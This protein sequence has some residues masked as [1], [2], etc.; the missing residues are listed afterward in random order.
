MTQVDL[1][2]LSLRRYVDLVKRRRWQ[3][4]PVSL[5]GLLVGG[6]V[7]FFIP[8]MYVAETVIVH[9]QLPGGTEDPE[10]PF[11]LIVETAKSSIPL[12]VEETLGELLWPEFAALDKF[13]QGQYARGVESR[14]TVLEQN[15]GDSTRSYA[16]LRVFYRD[17]D[18][19]RSAQLLNKLVQVWMARRTEE[20]RK[21]AREQ[22]LEAKEKADRALDTVLR[23]RRVKAELERQYGIDPRFSIEDQKQ[24]YSE[25]TKRHEL[26]RAA[27]RDLES[28]YD[29]L[30]AAIT[31]DEQDL[32]EMQARIVPQ[33]QLWLEAGMADKK[34]APLVQMALKSMLSYQTTFTRGS[35]NWWAAKRD[36]EAQVAYIKQLLPKV[37]V[38]KDGMVPNPA[39]ALKLAKIQAD[40]K[41]LA[42]LAAEIARKKQ[43]WAKEAADLLKLK[44]GYRIYENKLAEIREAEESRDEAR[45]TWLDAEKQD[46]AL[47]HDLPVKQLRPALP[48]PTP[49]E[50]NIMVVAL[51]GCVLGLFAAIGLILLF[52][53]L[54]GS[55]KSLEDVE[56]G[57]GVPVLGGVSHLETEM[58]RVSAQRS[59]RRVSLVAAAALLMVTAIVTIFYL[60]PNRLPTVVRDVLRVLLLDT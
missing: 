7:A 5:L 25:Q 45:K 24:E 43:I 48:P 11:R 28:D 9:S 26:E 53:F 6:V 29:K 44:D 54:Q 59:R 16:T 32:A 3:V 31:K 27:L 10:H 42:V 52:D 35:S 39:H 4:V 37:P 23:G 17:R 21:P 49:T 34:I 1:P 30:L 22:S 41:K 51:A 8:R 46:A 12:Y 13:G 55:F 18:G 38:D 58:E 57:L 47:F 33:D 15:G 40:Q 2:Q 20:V 36:Y 14:V 19:D 60:D 56:R 50:P